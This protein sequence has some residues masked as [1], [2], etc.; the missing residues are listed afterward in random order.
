MVFKATEEEDD[1][2]EVD[3]E[4]ESDNALEQ[5]PSEDETD[6]DVEAEDSLQGTSLD[7][8]ETPVRHRPRSHWPESPSPMPSAGIAMDETSPMSIASV[9]SPMSRIS[10]KASPPRMRPLV[11][12]STEDRSCQRVRSGSPSKSL[13]IDPSGKPIN[14][15]RSR[16]TSPEKRT[17]IKRVSSI[18]K[19]RSKGRNK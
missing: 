5:T 8:G 7:I 6:E 11:S 2:S 3:S 16:S 12:P 4:E 19:A 14:K 13:G 15:T 17:L 18:F 1:L 10:S 9:A